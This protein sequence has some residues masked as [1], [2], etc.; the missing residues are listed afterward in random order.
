MPGFGGV[1]DVLDSV[2]LAA[3]AAY[4]CWALKLV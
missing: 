1:L 2:L 3:P 4:L